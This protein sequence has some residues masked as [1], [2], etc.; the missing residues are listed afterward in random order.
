MII[1]DDDL[2][3]LT[4]KFGNPNRKAL[5][6]AQFLL[7]R[8]L[9]ENVSKTYENVAFSREFLRSIRCN[10]EL[11][12][13]IEFLCSERELLDLY[14]KRAFKTYCTLITQNSP[15]YPQVLIQKLGANAPLCL[16]AKG[17]IAGINQR[18]VSLVG[19][20]NISANNAEFAASVGKMAARND[21]ALVSGN[22]RGADSIGQNACLASGGCVISIVADSLE[23]HAYRDNVLYLSEEAFD[24]PFSTARALHR[25]HLIHS[26]G[27][28]TFVAQCTLGTGGTWNG[29]V[30]NLKNNWSPVFGFRDHSPASLALESMG[31]ELIDIGDLQN[32]RSLNHSQCSLFV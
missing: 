30:K 12:D 24:A 5:T 28:K 16:W 25:N 9:L 7:L 31:A 10:P 6:R 1:S 29:T 8:R 21:Y 23:S 17:D 3:L 18:C 15:L 19:S 27:E 14:R 11:S 2:L 32:M 22:A 26:L 4:A 13:Q 20:R